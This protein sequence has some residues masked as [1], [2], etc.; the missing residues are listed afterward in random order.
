MNKKELNCSDTKFLGKGGEGIIVKCKDK[1]N[2]QYAIKLSDPNILDKCPLI[3]E[4]ENAKNINNTNFTKPII[5]DTKFGKENIIKYYNSSVVGLTGDNVRD[6]NTYE[7]ELIEND[8]N[9]AQTEESRQEAIV[10]KE[11][12]M[13]NIQEQINHAMTIQFS[14]PNNEPQKC[15]AVLEFCDQGDLHKFIR[16]HPEYIK[17]NQLFMDMVYQIFN[18]LVY[19]YNKKI[20]HWDLKP[21]NILV[22]TN[23]NSITGKINTNK[24]YLFKIADY[25]T[26]LLDPINTINERLHSVGTDLMNKSAALNF[27]KNKMPAL[28]TIELVAADNPDIDPI[29]LF[30]NQQNQTYKTGEP[31]D[32]SYEFQTTEAY[33][34]PNPFELATFYRDIYAFVLSIF[35]LLHPNSELFKKENGPTISNVKIFKMSVLASKKKKNNFIYQYYKEKP[36]SKKAKLLWDIARIV[37]DIEEKIEKQSEYLY[38]IK[39][40]YGN[41]YY[42][43]QKYIIDVPDNLFNDLYRRIRELFESHNNSSHSKTL[44]SRLLRNITKRHKSIKR[45]LTPKLVSGVKSSN[46]IDTHTYKIPENFGEDLIENKNYFVYFVNSSK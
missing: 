29:N 20:C 18:G 14:G 22:K 12:V 15:L 35:K 4:I 3:K 26:V 38:Y 28:S 23:T 16:N 24:K 2:K 19:L 27:M 17:D 45:E 13:K 10:R 8:I 7:M 46:N 42:Q 41:T 36:W 40:P 21:E 37:K 34:P 11:F 43:P 33:T 31:K 39:N 32:I 6:I 9:N 5:F 44:K 1:F 25:G 30:I